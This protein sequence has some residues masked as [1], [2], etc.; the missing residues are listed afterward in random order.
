MNVARFRLGPIEE[1]M[2]RRE[3]AVRIA[4]AAGAVVC[5]LL[6]VVLVLLAIDVARVRVC[7]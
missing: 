6:A 5:L 2:S 1:T 7:C 3:L 4:I